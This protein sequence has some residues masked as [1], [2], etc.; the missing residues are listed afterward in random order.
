M[1]IVVEVPA[2]FGIFKS[3]LFS[4]IKL[5]LQITAKTI[6][7]INFQLNISRKILSMFNKFPEISDLSPI[8][9]IDKVFATQ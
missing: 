1:V 3:A 8:S 7:K 6:A 2:S 9:T 4:I 5:I